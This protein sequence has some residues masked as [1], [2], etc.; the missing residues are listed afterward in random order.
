[1]LP[2]CEPPTPVPIEVLPID[3]EPSDELPAAE[4]PVADPVAAP[5]WPAPEVVCAKATVDRAA[6]MVAVMICLRMLF[7]LVFAILEWN[8]FT[9]MRRHVLCKTRIAGSRSD[10]IG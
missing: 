10:V 1:M 5:L 9:G 2:V 7:S 8:M 6:S 3:D 4:L